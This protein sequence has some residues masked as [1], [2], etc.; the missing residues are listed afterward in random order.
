[1]NTC[2]RGVWKVSCRLA[3]LALASVI[4]L[5]AA[6]AFANV[7]VASYYDGQSVALRFDDA[8]TFLNMTPTGYTT[9][10]AGL[11]HHVYTAAGLTVTRRSADLSTSNVFAV[12]NEQQLGEGVTHINRVYIDQDGNLYAV[13]FGDGTKLRTVA[14][15]ASDGTYI[16]SFSSP[17]LLRPV[18]A[19]VDADGN[20]YVGNLDFANGHSIFV[21]D[22]DG[23][24]Q[25]SI[26]TPGLVPND[27]TVDWLTNTLYIG[28]DR[29]TAVRTFNIGSGE[30]GSMPVDGAAYAVGVDFS[31]LTGLLYVADY[32]TNVAYA[33]NSRGDGAVVG[34]YTFDGAYGMR[35]ITVLPEP[36]SLL[37]LGSALVASAGMVLRRRRG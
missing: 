23:F 18:G 25:G 4:V 36:G 14:K 11:D 21:W 27:L 20:V 31:N 24:F 13:P 12:A 10:A 17:E 37:A 26:T 28:E 32:N 5:G 15:Y 35:D 6:P 2:T 8:G 30:W 33:I 16:G 7:Y 19:A 1:M 3:L 34:T 22:S 29:G 9:I